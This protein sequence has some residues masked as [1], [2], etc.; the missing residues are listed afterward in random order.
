LNRRWLT[1]EG[2][3]DQTGFRGVSNAAYESWNKALAERYYPAT[4]RGRPAY[5]CLDDDELE[6]I[7]PMGVEPGAQSLSNAVGATLGPGESRFAWH[8]LARDRWRASE[9]GYPPYVALL[10]LCVLAAS[11]MARDGE[12]GIEA[13]AYYPHLNPLLGRDTFA[14][15]PP[16][17]ELVGSLW[18]DLCRW[19]D[20]HDGAYGTSTARQHPHFIHVGWPMSQCLLRRAD[21][22]RLTEFFRAAGL[23]PHE[24]IEPGQL[25]VLFKAWARPGCGLSTTAL[26][27]ADHA[28]GP[29]AEQLADILDREYDSWEGELL[30]RRGR[31]R[32]LIALSVSMLAG[33]RRIQLGLSPRRADG[34][35]TEATLHDHIGRPYPITAVSDDWYAPLEVPV[36]ARILAE[37]LS[38]EGDGF[39]FAYEE[40]D[41][42]PLRASLGAAA[43]VSVR[44]ADLF[45][46]HCVLF[47]APRRQ[48][49]RDF[50]SA[51]A[52]S[53]WTEVQ[54]STLPSGWH[55]IRGV[56]FARAISEAPAGLAVLAPRLHTATR[57][58]GGL[59]IAPA[60]YLT[61]GEPDVWIS[62]AGGHI[63]TVILDGKEMRANGALELRLSALNPPLKEGSH[64]LVVS[65]ITRHFATSSGFPVTA[66]LGTGAYG[67]VFEL[68]SGY[69]PKSVHAAKLERKPPPRGTVYVSGASVIGHE[70]DLPKPLTEPA[71]IPSGLA[72][73]VVLGSSPHEVLQPITPN[74][75]A[76][77]GDLV[78]GPA[79]FFD[80]PVPFE[81]QWV[82]G[83]GAGRLQVRPLAADPRPPDIG[84]ASANEV[85]SAEWS[86]AILRASEGGARPLRHSTIWDVYVRA[87]SDLNQEQRGAAV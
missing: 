26:R 24:E 15:M 68:H 40:G 9:D 49:V 38:L 46:E 33:G 85:V 51:H 70:A 6:E 44:Q 45:E 62:V 34:L 37:G 8:I 18:E 84:A 5:L 78:R 87:A 71:L 86:S 65:G 55:V 52:Q 3:D 63:A 77:I 64:E 39:S 69:R 32:G 16:G 42:V 31:R 14:G 11:R 82:I 60:L 72:D 58:A 17:F 81:P 83:R 1:P 56:R 75:P 74:R 50:L 48:A 25:W 29:I 73:C 35:P 80:C 4:N 41:V 27:I 21:R 61:Q 13:N 30:D 7:E 54:A 67:H 66:A 36:T 10:G 43:W 28:T 57:I 76:W 79:Q 2:K 20:S 47:S 53:G 59:Q 12:R 23:D 22:H 19:L